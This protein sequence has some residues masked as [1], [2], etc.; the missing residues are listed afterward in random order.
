[1]V[2]VTV[3]KT[4]TIKQANDQLTTKLNKQ[5]VRFNQNNYRKLTFFLFLFWFE[6]ER[7]VFCSCVHQNS[8][9][10]FFTATIV[11]VIPIEAT[12]LLSSAFG[13]LFGGAIVVVRSK[14][15]NG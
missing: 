5:T 9:N 14:I 7:K 6:R 12:N 1:M 15:G 13:F 8:L 3:V 4:V 2:F 10:S 11:V